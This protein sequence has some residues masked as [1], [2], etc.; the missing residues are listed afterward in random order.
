MALALGIFL[1]VIW[2][3]VSVLWRNVYLRLLPILKT[4]FLFRCW[5]KEFFIYSWWWTRL[6]KWFTNIF[7]CSMGCLFTFLIILMKSKISIFFLVAYVFGVASKKPLQNTKLWRFTPMFS[8]GNFI[9][10][11]C[12]FRFLI[13]FGWSFACK[14]SYGFDFTL[15]Y[16]DIQLSQHCMLKI[17]LLF[18]FNF[19]PLHDFGNRVR[20]QLTII[21]V[22]FWSLD[23]ILLI[24]R[25]VLMFSPYCFD[26]GSFVACL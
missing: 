11:A 22:Y 2:P 19:L 7:S 18:F 26:Y 24:Y 4:G 14:V 3:F 1:Y 9:F 20:S 17:L 15:L 13:Y 23:S 25:S 5:V 16:V 12:I 21:W 6:R 8:S 10:L